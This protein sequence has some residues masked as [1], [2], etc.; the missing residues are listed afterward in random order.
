MRL[1][2]R[3][4]GRQQRGDGGAPPGRRAR[5]RAGVGRGDTVAALLPSIPAMS[6]AR[7][8]VPMAG[9]VLHALNRRLDVAWLLFWL[10]PGEA[11]GL[12]VSHP[13]ADV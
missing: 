13:A 8:A 7:S 1:E 2:R 3:R 11:S 10:P 6:E 12:V 5:E 9:A 4:T